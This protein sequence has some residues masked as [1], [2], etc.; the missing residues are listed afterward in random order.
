[1]TAL[2]TAYARVYHATHDSPVIFDDSLADQLFSAEEHVF[3]DKGLADSLKFLDPERAA[4]YPDQASA[5]AQY[6]HIQG[7]PIAV[8]RARYTEDALAV[9]VD[10]GIQQYVILGAGMDLFAFRKPDLVKRL[11]VFEIDH[12]ATQAMK[13]ERIVKVGWAIPEQLHFVAVDFTKENL[14]DTLK[15]SAYDPKSPSFFSWLG[16]TYYLTRE[17]V[18]ATLRAITEIAPRGSSI[19]FDYMDT[20][21]FN[22]EKAAKRV[23]KMQQIVQNV[24]EPM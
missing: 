17:V 16:V 4:Q 15:Q 6:M 22:P 13:R 5:L 20:D 3:F 10:Q 7:A 2:L 18:F 11:Q 23:Q 12:P 24:G 21:A 9:A 1:M 14:A 8:S 19:I